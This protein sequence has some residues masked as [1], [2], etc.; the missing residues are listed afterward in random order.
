MRNKKFSLIVFALIMLMCVQMMPLAFADAPKYEKV[1]KIVSGSQ[2]DLGTFTYGGHTVSEGFA[3]SISMMAA[4]EPNEWSFSRGA[5]AVSLGSSWSEDK[6]SYK[7]RASKMWMKVEGDSN[8]RIDTG[9]IA[10]NTGTGGECTISW[11]IILGALEV[12]L[13][14]ILE[15]LAETPP[16][17]EFESDLHW[18]KAIVRS[19]VAYEGGRLQPRY[20]PSVETA[21]CDF[22]SLFLQKGYQYLT[23]TAGADICLVYSYWSQ[24]DYLV[25][26]TIPIGTYSVTF[27]VEVPVTNEPE[28]PSKPLGTTSGYVGSSYTY[29]SDAIDPE[30]DNI[31]FQFDWGDGS[32]PTTTGW[33]TSGVTASASHT[34]GSSG[35]YYVRVRAQDVYEEWSNWSP[36]LA[37]S[38]SGSGGGG[39]GGGGGGCHPWSISPWI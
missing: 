24:G 37:V 15:Y 6:Y 20:N 2:S 22:N 32:T 27:E 10:D 12:I 33:Y 4:V 8:F 18:A 23:I 28:T 26:S 39:G 5:F 7:P 9:G 25:W 34:W 30:D 17:E 14:Y 11:E 36:S 21:G 13:P 16:R 38:I 29:S 3:V 1:L 19:K 35:T 31:R